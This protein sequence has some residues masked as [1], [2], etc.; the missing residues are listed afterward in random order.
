MTQAREGKAIREQAY[1]A[2]GDWWRELELQSLRTADVEGAPPA[3]GAEAHPPWLTDLAQAFLSSTVAQNFAEA[4]RRLGVAADDVAKGPWHRVWR[5]LAIMTTVREGLADRLGPVIAELRQLIDDIP[6][7]ERPTLARAYQ[8]LGAVHLRLDDLESGRIALLQA[9]A[10]IEESPA[11]LW[12]LDQFGQ[13]MMYRGVW[14][15]ARRVL[16]AVSSAKGRMGD[17]LGLAIT[18]GHVALLELQIGAPESAREAARRA[19]DVAGLPALS[20][21][22]LHNLVMQSFLE[23]EEPERAIAEA[24]GL[25][26]RL[27][28]V[29]RDHPEPHH[30][31]GRAALNLARVAS[32]RGDAAAA[33]HWLS[34][35]ALSLTFAED[36]ALVA[37]WRARLL[38][39]PGSQDDRLKEVLGRGRDTGMLGEAHLLACLSLA[40]RAAADRLA[41]EARRHLDAALAMAV[42][43]NKP[44]WIRRVDE[45]Y[46]R[47][48]PGAFTTRVAARYSGVAESEIERTRTV[49]ATLVFVDLVGFSSRAVSM[50]P[51]EV[52]ATVRSI[53][54]IGVPL[55]RRF[56]VRPLQ[57]LGDGLLAMCEG[58]GHEFRGLSLALEYV[59][60]VDRV[61]L[62]RRALGDSSPLQV[63]A[64]VASGDVVF[65]PL[66][67]PSNLEYL[68]I[69][70]PTNL[71]ARLQGEA[72]P[73]EVVCDA[74][75]AAR[76]G[77]EAPLERL[78]V[79]GYPE[80]VAAVRLR[81]RETARWL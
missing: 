20:R 51:L 54:E 9:L 53:F 63:R 12:I 39:G 14:S 16:L 69:G 62:V 33:D 32:L 70:Q 61:A 72:K 28:E 52:M 74:A 71:A 17:E 45:A 19:L 48:D 1:P 67:D 24:G 37:L 68:A 41:A 26:Q 36:Q 56:Q 6:E 59:R 22:R 57:H 46:L 55:L 25:Q 58:E 15:E 40:E 77:F 42:R 64:G 27:D 2:P 7:T 81:P 47:I 50:A 8:T 75:T 10:L 79:K 80:P 60:E 34:R 21:L 18:L 13:L 49:A 38:P 78:A 43:S 73:G 65:G 3:A 31:K 29:E 66:G 76:A 4:R 30:Q 35:A 5:L 44:A 23:G 11:K